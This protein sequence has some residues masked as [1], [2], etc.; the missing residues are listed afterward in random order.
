MK[1]KKT[2]MLVG[3]AAVASSILLGAGFEAGK[4]SVDWG[5]PEWKG[6]YISM[7]ATETNL[8]LQ[9]GMRDDGVVVWRKVK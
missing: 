9:I 8:T 2:L 4:A 3:L 7:S 5:K 1:L 6:G